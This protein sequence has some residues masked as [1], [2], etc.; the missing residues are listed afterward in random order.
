MRPE[1]NSGNKL[2]AARVPT[3]I[4]VISDIGIPMYVS[5]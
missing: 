3:Y 1:R 2:I 4:S 5:R